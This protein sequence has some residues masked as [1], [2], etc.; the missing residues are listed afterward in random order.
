MGSL[1]Y[2]AAKLRVTYVNN[3]QYNE[4]AQQR[5]YA[6]YAVW[7]G[8]CRMTNDKWI[9]MMVGAWAMAVAYSALR[10]RSIIVTGH[11]TT[12]STDHIFCMVSQ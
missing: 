2:V 11:G 10:S 7:N 12:L 3:E 8:K 5:V 1:Q 6:V 9:M 4:A